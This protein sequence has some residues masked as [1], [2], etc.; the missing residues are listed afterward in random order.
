MGDR[1]SL[2][3]LRR[4]WWLLERRKVKSQAKLSILIQVAFG[5]VAFGLL[6]TLAALSAQG[7]LATSPWPKFHANSA[8]TGQG[9]GGVTTNNLSWTSSVV[10]SSTPIVGADG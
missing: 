8:N 9:V 6:C 7:Q 4:P 2:S 10:L 5:R 3:S 1:W